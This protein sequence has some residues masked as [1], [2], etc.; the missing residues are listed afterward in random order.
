MS[1]KGSNVG[2]WSSAEKLPV[3][4]SS[5]LIPQQ[6]TCGA[7]F[8]TSAQGR[9]CCR[10]RLKRLPN[11]DSVVLTRTSAEIGDDGAEQ[12]GTRAAVLFV[13]SRRGRA[14]R[15]PG[16]RNCPRSRSVVGLGRAGATLFSYWTAVDRSGA[17]DPD[18]HRR[19]RVRH[20]LGTRAVPRGPAQSRLS[21]VLWPRDRGQD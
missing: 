8:G 13:Q 6:R 5:L 3:S 18:A 11:S 10:S 2:F 20:S 16:T 21:L 19:L 14:A 17:D 1:S 7:H 9:F 4:K 12:P 15:S